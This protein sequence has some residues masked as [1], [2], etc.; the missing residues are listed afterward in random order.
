MKISTTVVSLTNIEAPVVPTSTAACSSNSCRAQKRNSRVPRNS[1]AP[2]R[3]IAPPNTNMET[4]ITT[5]TLPKP[6]KPS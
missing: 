1:A 6:E 2:V 3:T 5:A 4:T